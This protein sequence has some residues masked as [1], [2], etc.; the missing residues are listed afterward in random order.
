MPGH[1]DDLNSLD[2]MDALPPDLEDMHRLLLRDGARWRVRLPDPAPQTP[3]EQQDARVDRQVGTSPTV[4]PDTRDSQHIQQKIRKEVFMHD[5]T[6][7][8]DRP[9]QRVAPPSPAMSRIRGIAAVGAAVAIVALFVGLIYA[10]GPG[11]SNT[12]VGSKPSATTQAQDIH[13]GTL[14]CSAS[15]S[16]DDTSSLPTVDW[17]ASGVIAAWHSQ[18][19]AFDGR[20]CASESINAQERMMGRPIWSPD[21]KRL[22]LM[23]LLSPQVYD[24]STGKV[25]ATL[26]RKHGQQFGSAAWTP[27]GTQIVTASLID[28]VSL[29]GLRPG[30]VY[31]MTVQVW[32]ASTGALVR[33]VMTD[34]ILTGTAVV[35]PN[36]KYFTLR[37]ADQGVQIRSVATGE[38]VGTT[39]PVIPVGMVWSP[40]GAY[41]AIMASV[42][43]PNMVS[44][45]EVQIWSTTGQHIATFVDDN[46]WDGMVHALAFSPDGKYLAESSREIHIWNVMTQKLVATFGKG[47]TQVTASDDKQVAPH[48]IEALAWARDGH[49]LA[50]VTDNYFF[51]NVEAT[52]NVWKLS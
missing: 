1:R 15:Y 13:T 11:H 28:W 52:L 25:I 12:R 3:I 45:T 22:L 36:A 6:Q 33:T 17:S 43:H 46:T 50:S 2:A 34:Q 47:E 8:D 20:T 40:D 39:S 35:S 29:P 26:Q 10:F 32:D 49:T 14:L 4:P 23:N 27:D 21:G 5:T 44:T 9:R 41:L 51:S 30:S 31:V 19:K 37:K 18:Y 24:F 7:I 38:L 16:V 42:P 48:P